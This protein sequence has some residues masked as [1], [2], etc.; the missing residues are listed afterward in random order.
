[1]TFEGTRMTVETKNHFEISIIIPF[2]N[3]VKN[4]QPLYTKLKD[5]LD[6]IGREYE[7][8]FVDDGSTDGTFLAL[9]GIYDS[10]PRVRIIQL[11]RN[12]GQTAA[13]AAGFDHAEGDIIISMD[14]DLQ[15]DPAEIPNF[16]AKIDEGYD[17]VSGWRKQRVD[18]L[19]TRKIPSW[20][21]NKLM[22]ILSGVNLHD[23]GTTYKAYRSDVIKNIQLYGEMHRFVPAL[24][25]RLGAKIYEIPIRNV[26]RESGAS[27][28][29]LSRTKGVLLDLLVVKFLLSYMTNPMRMFGSLGLL[30]FSVG[31]FTALGLVVW[32]WLT[33]L[34]IMGYHAG[35]LIF[36]VLAMLMGVQFITMGLLSEMSARIYQKIDARAVYTLRNAFLHR[37][38]S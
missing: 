12:F 21:A 11:R 9:K 20:M 13:L 16:L 19:I 35:L 38:N 15:H 23:F 5:V 29:G 31:F 36:S 27:H 24:A 25:S 10:D 1:M 30:S 34:N 28:Y 37:N 32:S 3:E 22:A 18:N 8:I 26:L 7:L 14:G 33:G 17:I 6:R 2:C 4:I